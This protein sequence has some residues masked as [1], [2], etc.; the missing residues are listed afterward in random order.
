MKYI[1]IVITCILLLFSC[2]NNNYETIYNQEILKISDCKNI[3]LAN[4]IL[5][6]ETGLEIDQKIQ[7]VTTDYNGGIPLQIENLPIYYKA[8]INENQYK[9]YKERLLTGKYSD[10]WR[11]YEENE[12]L[13]FVRFNKF[14]LACRLKKDTI[15]FGFRNVEGI[16]P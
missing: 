4:W 8:Q 13:D 10:S 9:E 7:I 5:L 6:N 2:R 11:F 16:A 12:H 1:S 3:K 15:L 14:E